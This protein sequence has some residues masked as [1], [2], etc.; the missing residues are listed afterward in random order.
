MHPD[1]ID[2]QATYARHLAKLCAKCA[3]PETVKAVHA[4]AHAAVHALADGHACALLDQLCAENPELGTPKVVRAQLHQSGVVGTGASGEALLPL[5]L[6][7]EDRLY[8]ARFHR[9]EQ[10]LGRALRTRLAAPPLPVSEAAIT[11]LQALPRHPGRDGI[12]WQLVAI[13][14][15]LRAPFTVITG[16]PGTGKTTTT[17]NLLAVLRHSAP[18]LR[19]ALAAPTGKASSRLSASIAQNPLFAA[20]GDQVPTATTLHRLLDYQPITDRFRH[21]PDRPLPYDLVVVDEASMIDLE[22]MTA[23]LQ[24]LRPDARL[25]LLGDRD[26]LASVGSGQVLADL[27][28]AAEPRRGVGTALA[29][30]CLAHLGMELPVQQPDRPLANG[31]IA[32]RES[33]RFRQDSDIGAFAGAVAARDLDLART[34][35]ERGGGNLHRIE[36]DQFDAAVETLWKGLTASMKASSAE[37]A[38]AALE[39]ARILCATRQGPHS[40]AAANAAV[41]ARLRRQGHDLRSPYYCGRPVL[42]TQNDHAQGLYNGDLG[43]LWSLPGQP[44]QAWFRE[45]SQGVRSVLPQRLPM[46]ETAWAMTVHKCQGSE[47]DRILLWLP[48]RDSPLTNAPLVYTAVTRARTEATIAASPEIL[49]RALRTEPDRATGLV[50]LLLDSPLKNGSVA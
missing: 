16:G 33:H 15:A 13:A 10:H 1:P 35:L 14:A 9:A 4:A 30:F 23:L 26:Q 17:A 31:V 40:V 2:G 7:T 32:L 20:L 43:V 41:E 27:C 3:R 21:G 39:Q 38:L 8:L 46:H 44:M 47:F 37:A 34:V 11:A 22:L 12:D 36:S 48:D 28:A 19:V 29:S 42:V 50:S 24:A 5:V 25:I 18:S 6:D 45:G 49:L